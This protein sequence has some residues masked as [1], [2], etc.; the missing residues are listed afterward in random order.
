M[1]NTWKSLIT[2]TAEL[3]VAVLVFQGNEAATNIL[4][5]YAWFGVFV[6]FLLTI[7]IA[8]ESPNADKFRAELAKNSIPEWARLVGRAADGVCVAALASAGSVATAVLYLIALMIV[9]GCRGYARERA[10]EVKA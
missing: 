2:T 3:A 6:A 1:S 9:I 5:A 8:H 4:L 10:A 7:L